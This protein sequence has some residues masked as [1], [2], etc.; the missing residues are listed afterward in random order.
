M[1]NPHS[2]E[3]QEEVRKWMCSLGWTE[4]QNF[5]S[6]DSDTE[7]TTT[8]SKKSVAF[9]YKL[10]DTYTAQQSLKRA[11]EELE[12]LA[13]LDY[14]VGETAEYLKGVNDFQEIIKQAINHLDKEIK[15]SRLDA[16]GGDDE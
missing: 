7:M 9:F 13:E 12:Q 5:W 2:R 14:T 4:H 15:A 8:M 3:Q 11:K 10:F 16:E 1:T 6:L